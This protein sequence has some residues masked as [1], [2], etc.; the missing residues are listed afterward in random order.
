[1]PNFAV[2]ASSTTIERGNKLLEMY[3][4][5]GEKKEDALLRILALAESEM[6]K[7]THPEIEEKLKAV[8]ETIGVLIKQVNGIVAG[9][10]AQLADLKEKLDAAIEEKRGA[11]EQ[12]QKILEEAKIKEEEDDK[13]IKQASANMEEE[14]LKAQE[15][16]HTAEKERDQALRE[17]DDAR[18]IAEEKTASNNLLLKQMQGMELDVEA[19][20][21]LQEKYASL[22]SEYSAMREVLKEKERELDTQKKEARQEAEM[23]KIQVE[24][25]KERA[26]IEKERELR[27]VFQEKLRQVDRESAKLM[28]ELEQLKMQVQ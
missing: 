1:M 13:A 17:R 16:I 19:Y 15:S 11:L 9:Q 3:S 6:V 22:E 21:D 25:E 28:A 5:D 23:A 27:E 24:L 18:V 14:K 26:V 20:K 8:E 4:R 2:A 12:A 10:D 7:G